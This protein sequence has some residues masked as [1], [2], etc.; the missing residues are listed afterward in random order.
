MPKEVE[1][2]AAAV[3]AD[4]RRE[5]TLIGFRF[6]NPGGK[7]WTYSNRGGD[8]SAAELEAHVQAAEDE[9]E[10]ERIY[11]LAA[12]PVSEAGPTSHADESLLR[13]ASALLR[14]AEPSIKNM[15]LD[16]RMRSLADRI[17]M[18]VASSSAVAPRPQERGT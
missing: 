2:P 18:S 12:L 4:A 1:V 17:D 6:R 7:H 14:E 9:W 3:L 11:T 16:W 5:P 15:D 8:Q 13:Q 10:V